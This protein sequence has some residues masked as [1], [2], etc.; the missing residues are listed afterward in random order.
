MYLTCYLELAVFD[1]EH[2]YD[3]V[4]KCVKQWEKQFDYEGCSI[5]NASSFI[6]FGTYML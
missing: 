5:M 1:I 6:T 4:S 3:L 2:V